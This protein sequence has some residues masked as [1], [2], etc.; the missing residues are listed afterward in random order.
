MLETDV[1]THSQTLGRAWGILR[2]RGRNDLQE[3]ERSS[4]ETRNLQNQLTRAHRD[5]QSL[6]HQPE[7]MHGT[8]LS[9]LH[10]CNSCVAWFSYG[11]PIIRVWEGSRGCLWLCCLLLLPHL[12]SEGEDVCSFTTTWYAK[13]VW[14]PWEASLFLK[15]RLSGWWLVWWGRERTGS[16]RGRGN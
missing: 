4:T 3:P 16:R 8:D 12:A 6:S 11:T 10:I 9:P 14:Y 15:P 5:S 2:K 7:S 13:A 1:E